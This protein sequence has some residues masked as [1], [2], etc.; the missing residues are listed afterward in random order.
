MIYAYVYTMIYTDVCLSILN[1]PMV[2]PTSMFFPVLLMQ[3][4][5][6]FGHT[7]HS[8]AGPHWNILEFQQRLWRFNLYICNGQMNANF[9][10][11]V[12]RANYNMGTQ[13]ECCGY[14]DAIGTVVIH[15]SAHNPQ[16][17]RRV[18][19]SSEGLTYPK[20]TNLAR[21]H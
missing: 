16:F 3:G 21:K 17:R 11:I 10:T 15:V 13:C 4:G 9:P 5:H 7:K 19:A 18:T 14:Q 1:C 6:S 2:L 20:I 8:Q 12:R